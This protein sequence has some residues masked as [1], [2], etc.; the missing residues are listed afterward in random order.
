MG[1]PLL[2][3]YGDSGFPRK[4]SQSS[5]QGKLPSQHVGSIQV[6]KNILMFEDGKI[7]TDRV[8]THET[9]SATVMNHTGEALTGGSSFLTRIT[10]QPLAVR[11]ETEAGGGRAGKC[12]M[13]PPPPCP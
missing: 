8:Y 1:T 10:A 6:F 7:S 12:V 9:L 13:G 3:E 5:Q 4:S 11:T 2:N